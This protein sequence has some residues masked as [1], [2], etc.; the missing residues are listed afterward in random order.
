MLFYP[1][2]VAVQA[3]LGMIL[4]NVLSSGYANIKG[5]DKPVYPRSLVSAFVVRLL[6]NI[7]SNLASS[8][9]SLFYPVFVAEESGL[10]MILINVLSSG[11]ANIKGADKPVYPRSLVSAFVVR[12]L[13]NII[14]NLASSEISLFYPVF[15]A[16]QSGLGMILINVLSSGYANIKGADKPAHPR[17]LVSAFAVRLIRNI[18]S[19]LASSEI[20]LFYPV[21]VA[22]QSGLGMILI[23]VLLTIKPISPDSPWSLADLNLPPR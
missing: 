12:L 13:G 19:N 15:V 2:F 17:S 5:A 16:E 10:G 7:I 23:H 21:F 18:I 1:V 14:S 11:Y 9:I 8:E 4:I 22:E 3:G 6:G 20:S